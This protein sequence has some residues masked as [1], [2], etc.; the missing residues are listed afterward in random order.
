MDFCLVA[1]AAAAV[2]LYLEVQGD[3]AATS[4]HY[5]L[6]SIFAATLFV[7]MFERSGGYQ[8][9]RLQLLRWQLRHVLMVWAV[10]VAVLLF[11]ASLGKISEIYSLGWGVV[12]FG[13]TASLLMMERGVLHFALTRWV[14]AGYLTRNIVILGAGSEGE[15][16]IAKLKHSQDPTVT[17]CGLFDDHK[18]QPPLSVHG[19]SVL[20]TTNDLIRFAR[21]NPVDEVIVALPLDA[22]RQL[23]EVF[24]KLKGLAVDLRL[25]IEPVARR[26]EGRGVSYLGEVPVLEIADRPL[27]HWRAGAKWIQDKVLSVLLLFGLAP[28]MA[29]IAIAIKLDSPGPVFFAQER[30]GFNNN[31]IRVLKFRTM[32][33]GLCDPSGSQRTVCNDPRVTGVGR[34]L[35]WLS[36]DELPQLVNVVRGDMSLVGPRPHAIA[37][38][39]G[40][41]L[42]GD[43]VEQYLHRHRVKPGITGWAQV[44]GLRGE[45]DTLEKAQRRLDHDLYYIDHWSPW[46]D[47][48]ILLMTAGIVVAP[49]NVY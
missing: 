38:K 29:G 11:G 27:K 47:L 30:F 9:K 23:K 31:V 44:N 34:V 41:H 32:H 8:L 16:L 1:G 5:T 18:S 43:A 7:T 37:M 17:I 26:Y 40:G 33:V 14:R 19:L 2:V 39:A 35:R 36:L 48:K 24:A 10:A 22:E 12:W 45:V 21:C 46:L 25:S 28:F 49:D 15:R 13:T 6:T 4:R 42:Y 20:G 3:S